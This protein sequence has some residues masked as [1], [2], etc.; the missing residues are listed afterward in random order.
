MGLKILCADQYKIEQAD[1]DSGLGD[2]LRASG[3][4]A[5]VDYL[6]ITVEQVCTYPRGN[7]LMGEELTDCDSPAI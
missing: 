2:Q 6:P 4:Q 5:G 3:L 1:Y 7:P